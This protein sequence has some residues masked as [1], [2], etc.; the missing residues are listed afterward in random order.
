MMTHPSLRGDGKKNVFA[1]DQ[2]RMVADGAKFIYSN[3][4]RGF[5]SLHS[6]RVPHP[7]SSQGGIFCQ[8]TGNDNPNITLDMQ[9]EDMEKQI[10][11]NDT[12]ADKHAF[13]ISPANINNIPIYERPADPNVQPVRISNGCPSISHLKSCR[14]HHRAL[15]SQLHYNGELY[16]GLDV[17]QDTFLLSK[18]ASK[19]MYTIGHTTPFGSRLCGYEPANHEVTCQRRC[20]NPLGCG[21][22]ANVPNDTGMFTIFVAKNNEKEGT[23]ELVRW[24]GI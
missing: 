3:A 1:W 4:A 19:G 10:S 22:K 11:T 24:D 17:D 20:M 15:D 13:A 14:K 8:T 9:V 23:V 16:C 5:C 21:H 18:T 7:D 12:F 2:T 6:E